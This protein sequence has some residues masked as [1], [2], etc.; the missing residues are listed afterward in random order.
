MWTKN[1]RKLVPKLKVGKDKEWLEIYQQTAEK[2]RILWYRVL[3][4]CW[5]CVKQDGWHTHTLQW[6][7]SLSGS[8]HA[9]A[10]DLSSEKGKLRSKVCSPVD[11][12]CPCF[13][14]HGLFPWPHSAPCSFPI[15]VMDNVVADSKLPEVSSMSTS[16]VT[17]RSLILGRLLE[18]EYI[19]PNIWLANIE[20]LSMFK[21]LLHGFSPWASYYP[22]LRIC[23][24]WH[25]CII[26][27][28]GYR[29][30][31]FTVSNKK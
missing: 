16:P 31:E 30:I 12:E 2:L 23:K 8:L 10:E 1:P 13:Q 4:I 18:T 21:C 5:H 7:S 22:F 19:F 25:V 11:Q 3:L 20:N 26:K 9:L 17:S 15:D 14:C 29:H 24:F 27:S 6:S 28:T